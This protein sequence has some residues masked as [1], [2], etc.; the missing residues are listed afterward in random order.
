MMELLL[1][2]NRTGVPRKHFHSDDVSR[3]SAQ[4]V[5]AYVAAAPGYIHERDALGYTPLLAACEAGNVDGV[6]VL[7]E[8]GS[9][10]NFIAGD[11]ETPLKAAILDRGATFDPCIADLLF[12]A[13]A[14]PNLGLTPPLHLAVARGDRELVAYLIDRGADPN[15]RDVDGDPP[16]F[17]AGVYNR[18]PDLATMR[19]LVSRGAD[20]TTTNGVN[21]TLEEFIGA[22]R[23]GSLR[24]LA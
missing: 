14:D 15:H 7:L 13:G 22:D 19:L 18:T 21:Q 2:R 6:R 1:P 8:A 9:D 5:R 10:P 16:L 23:F 4:E 12:A 11:G 20:P 3:F 17:W 24:R